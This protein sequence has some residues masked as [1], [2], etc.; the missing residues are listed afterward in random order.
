MIKSI[1]KI[2]DYWTVVLF[3]NVDYDKYNLIESALTDILVST[4]IIDE[5]YDEIGNIYNTGFTCTNPDYRTS[6]VGI[7]KTTSRDELINTL[8]HEADH[9]QMAICD[10]YDVPKDSEDAAY[11]MGYLFEHFYKT[12]S[13]LLC[14]Y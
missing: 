3:V 5:I 11:L 10:Y 8:S 12:C 9:V 4:R 1:I 7:N 2:K 13:K 6:V 14:N